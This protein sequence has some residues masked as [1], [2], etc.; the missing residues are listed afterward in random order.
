MLHGH[1]WK[2]DH[3]CNMGAIEAM[4]TRINQRLAG[5]DGGYACQADGHRGASPKSR[6]QVTTT[7]T[8]TMPITMTTHV[9][10]HAD[11]RQRLRPKATWTQTIPQS[12]LGCCAMLRQRVAPTTQKR[13]NC[14]WIFQVREYLC[15]CVVSKSTQLSTPSCAFN[16]PIGC[17]GSKDTCAPSGHNEPVQ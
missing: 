1:A 4:I 2:V 16:I 14:A 17:S 7:N 11:S 15:N 9:A 12:G 6:K 3:F 5:W 8:N 10:L 13:K